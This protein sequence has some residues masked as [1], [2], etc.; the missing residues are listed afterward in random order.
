M[1]GTRC[2]SAGGIAA[3][4]DFLTLAARFFPRG[5]D[6]HLPGR[7]ATASASAMRD[8]LTAYFC[9]VARYADG[10]AFFTS[11]GQDDLDG[12]VGRATCLA[13]AGGEVG[14]REML[15]RALAGARRSATDEEITKVTSSMHENDQ[16]ADQNKEGLRL[17]VV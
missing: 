2:L 10:A 4:Q 13:H 5:A 9:D 11:F 8:A 3:E 17:R 1:Y 12:L 6:G 16:L 15:G 14:A 7:W